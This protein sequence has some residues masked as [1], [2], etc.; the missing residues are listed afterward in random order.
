M[1][2]LNQGVTVSA[3][4]AAGPGGQAQLAAVDADGLRG[5][6]AV[7]TDATGLAA[8]L[9]L[10]VRL[11]QPVV[12]DQDLYL[13]A[14]GMANGGVFAGAEVLV[15]PFQPFPPAGVTYERFAQMSQGQVTAFAITAS[16]P[17]APSTTYR[18]SW[19][20]LT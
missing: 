18:F 9:L 12:A 7:R 19:R 15:T 8:G 16:G 13:Q 6:V 10:T 14:Q 11:A 1:A 17:L 4:P 5:L 3:G 20:V 2:I